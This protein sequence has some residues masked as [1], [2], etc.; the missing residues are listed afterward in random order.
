MKEGAITAAGTADEEDVAAAARKKRRMHIVMFS[1]PVL[2]LLIGGYLWFTSGRFVS[3]DNAYVQQDKVSIAAEVSGVIVEVGVR[4]NQPVKKGDLLYRIDPRPFQIALEQAEAQIAQAGV[5]VA[6]A[7]SELAGTNAD[8]VGASSNLAFA[9]RAFQRQAELLDRGFTT[10]ARYDEAQHAVQEARERLSN[11]NAQSANKRA[12]L[13]GGDPSS[14][15]A[16]LAAYA[17]RDQAKLNLARTVVRAPADGY[18][19]QTQR[20]QVGN[21]VIQSVPMVTVVRSENAWIQ[22]NYKETDLTRMAVGQP[23]KIEFDAYPELTLHGHV[24]SIGAGT[25]SEFSVLPA[26]NAT[27]NWVKVT[28]R[29]PVR[30]SIEGKP[31]RRMIA[32]LSTHVSVD[33]K[34]PEAKLAQ[35]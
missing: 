2:I 29:V 30:I 26:Q 16:L 31:D 11:A 13:R 32:G 1:V 27:G 22:A 34:P 15:P 12:A 21:M 17:A 14:E 3:T 6:E 19:S 23:A 5:D 25:G 4:E 10:R 9:Q 20:L 28:Q 8:V 33:T 18:A 24:E 35:K 7:R